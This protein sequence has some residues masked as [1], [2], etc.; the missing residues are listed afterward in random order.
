MKQA[1]FEDI[2]AIDGLDLLA[3]N[4][5]TL[6][7]ILDAG[8][9]GGICVAS[10]MVGA[11]MRRMIDEPDQ[12]HEIHESLQDVFKSTFVAPPAVATK[13]ALRL[14]GIDAGTVRLPYVD[15]SEDEEAQIRAVLERHGLLSAV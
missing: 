7:Q 15:A 11:E 4:D 8:G 13:A 6:A 3:G 9:T 14:L 2:R 5:D 10:H 1:R 12:R